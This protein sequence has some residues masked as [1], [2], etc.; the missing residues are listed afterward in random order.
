VKRQPDNSRAWMTLAVVA[1]QQGDAKQAEEA[2]GKLQGMRN[3]PPQLRLALAQ[4]ALAK[5][6]YR[7]R[8]ALAGGC[9]AQPS[10]ATWRPWS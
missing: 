10:P 3:L 6:G 1:S 8:A 5:Q 9:A 4:V 7:G 2:V